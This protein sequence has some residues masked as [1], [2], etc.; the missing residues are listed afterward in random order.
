MSLLFYCQKEKRQIGKK[1]TK[2][3]K[4]KELKK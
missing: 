4:K 2:E 1:E 3:K